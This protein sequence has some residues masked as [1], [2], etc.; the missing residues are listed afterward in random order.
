MKEDQ[1]KESGINRI[2][3]RR[4]CRR[5][6]PLS[7]RLAHSN[8][9]SSPRTRRGKMD[10]AELAAEM[11]QI[12][13]IPTPERIRQAKK[14]RAQ[15]L[16]RYAQW[17]KTVDKKAR[18][19]RDL[20]GEDPD[21]R[22]K[23][24]Q[25]IVLLEAA[26]RNDVDEALHQCC[27]DNSETM[28]RLLLEFNAD[29]NA[30]DTETVDSAAC[31]GHL[32]PSRHLSIVGITSQPDYDTRLVPEKRMLARPDEGI[33]S[34][35]HPSQPAASYSTGWTRRAPICCTWPCATASCPRHLLA[36]PG[37]GA[38]GHPGQG[39]LAAGDIAPAGA[40]R[41][42]SSRRWR[43]R[44]ADLEAK[45]KWRDSARIIKR[46]D[47]SDVN[48]G[49]LPTRLQ[50]VYATR[51]QMQTQLLHQSTGIYFEKSSV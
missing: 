11:A 21:R 45:L 43:V 4:A 47:E 17:S 35:R 39:R 13:K 29:V 5:N 16:K 33:S 46:P 24:S 19:V 36:G 31:R 34:R 28:C 41:E 25:N 51:P 48:H 42:R 1:A 44:G 8:S 50:K 2:L 22:V 10:H 18:K 3:D 30:R 49:I 37:A 26:A 23:F 27:I 9:P 7:M 40:S 20:T 12:D 32:R 14:R 15:Q 38:A 6:K